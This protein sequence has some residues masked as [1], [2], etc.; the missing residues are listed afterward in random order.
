MLPIKKFKCSSSVVAVLRMQGV[1]ASSGGVKSSLS[2]ESMNEAIEQAFACDKT[3]AVALIINSP[4][5]S[6]VQSELIYKR[7]RTL[8]E[9][10]K[11]PVIAFAEDV[12][13]SGG[14]W[15]MCA[16]DELYASENSVIGSIGVMAGGFGFQEAIKKLGIERRL[17]TQGKNKSV[18]DPFLPE[19]EED[20]RIIHNIQKDIH[21]SF[22]NLV[23]T[24]REGKLKADE[25]KLFNGEFWSGKEALEYGLIDNISDMYSVM[26]MRFGKDVKFKKVN[27]DK[28]WLKKKLGISIG[29]EMLD[30]LTEKLSLEK[31]GL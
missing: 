14:Y 27:K 23:R 1:I 13:A 3:R 24:R 15:L 25:E 17:Y 4:G 9:E 2:L 11:I 20:V 7:I 28:S 8:S 29:D 22:K 19:K 30:R 12:A 6:P 31:F 10:K 21:E 18:L 5:G 26:K 16:G